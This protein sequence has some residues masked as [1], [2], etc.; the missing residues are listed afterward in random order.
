MNSILNSYIQK[1]EQ[2]NNLSVNVDSLNA[3]NQRLRD[4]ISRITSE[5]YYIKVMNFRTKVKK[6]IIYKIYSR[7]RYG[8]IIP[9]EHSEPVMPERKLEFNY[10][11][12]LNNYEYSFLDYKKQRNKECM[13][14]IN[15][16]SVPYIKD[17]ISVVLPVYNGEDYVDLS[18]ESVLSQTY[19]NFEFIIIDDGSTDKTP[20]ILDSYA[21]KDS[22]IKVFHQENRKLPR[23]LSRGF[24]E[25]R[26]EFFT[27]TSADNIMH[28][29]FL[30]KFV[31]NLKKFEHTAMI[32]G[33]I[34][35]IDE[36]G[37]PKT[38]F[39]WYADDP[40]N[41]ENVILPKCILELNT[42]ANNFIGAAFM[43]RAIAANVVEDY[44][45]YKYGIEDYD[46]WMKINEL[47]TVRHTSFSDIEYSYRM[48]SKS[49]TSKDKEL[50][51]SENRYKQMLLDAFRRDYYLKQVYWIVDS[52]DMESSCYI[53]FCATVRKQG[54]FIISKEEAA[55]QT[56]N[57]Y[58]RFI[59]IAF[60]KAG[61][62]E[63]DSVPENA[64]KVLITEK[65]VEIQPNMFDTFIC[66]EKVSERDFIEPY[67]GW[68]GI[69]DGADIYA[70]VDSKARNSFLYELE[71]NMYECNDSKIMFST[72][73]TYCGDKIQLQNCINSIPSDVRSEVLIV[74][75]AEKTSE[76]HE[77]IDENIHVISCLSGDDVTQKNIA[78]RIAKG[79]FLLFL[80]SD[81]VLDIQSLSGMVNTFNM[82]ARIAVMFGN[83]EID[84]R[85]KYRDYAKILGEYTISSDDVY[86]YQECNIP[87]AYSF[88]AN[89]EQLKLVGGFYHLTKEY[90]NQFCNMAMFGLAMILKNVGRFLYLSKDFTVIRNVGE[91]AV[92]EIAPYISNEKESDYR[93]KISK[94]MPYN[95]WPEALASEI[96]VLKN[97]IQDNADDAIAKAR[98]QADDKLINLVREDFRNK[99]KAEVHR[100]MYSQLV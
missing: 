69:R 43:Y 13:L 23:T 28:P 5:P 67:K 58:E 91:T 74:A 81:C 15:Q 94:V 66:N 100:D 46:Y 50:K 77:V 14:N 3:E 95:I 63:V 27:W 53:D 22:R 25:A 88:A 51:I 90:R 36:D 76:L 10:D 41:L 73:I 93:L 79:K 32:Y 35:L 57:L 61:Q 49:L 29:Q 64:Y 6:T 54:H 71:G 82:D 78:I 87:S 18:I 99:E 92:K 55:K 65:P 1:K 26:G 31:E 30:E 47:F 89:A 80:Q 37:N 4:E 19:D 44:S 40:E 7:L 17:L 59:Y 45:Q 70:F 21:A 56:V 68:Y 75:S 83:V 86:E 9:E 8:K 98:L 33:N 34:R 11:N 38:D 62:T 39:G 72:I 16:I 97:I 52:D 24:R 12:M 85:K 96:S 20:Q 48:H 84:I 60:S 42:F 2:V